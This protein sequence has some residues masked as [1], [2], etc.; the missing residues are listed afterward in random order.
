MSAIAGIL[1]LDGAP[2][3]RE[4]LETLITPPVW[5]AP[6]AHAVWLDGHVGMA[7]ALV[8]LTP[9]SED[10]RQPLVDPESGTVV[11][12][13][14]R[15]DNRAD[16]RAHLPRLSEADHD[17]AY[18]L[19]AHRRW[20]DDLP[21]HLIGDFD[22]AVWDPRKRTLLLARDPLGVKTLYYADVGGMLVFASTL[23]QL[24]EDERIPRTVDERSALG[25]LYLAP[26]D[27]RSFY[28][29]IESLAPGHSLVVRPDG[30]RTRIFW[31]PPEHPPERAFMNA[32]DLEEYREVFT[33]VVRSRLRTRDPV[34]IPLSG[35]LDSGSIGSVAGWLARE[36]GV[37]PLRSYTWAFDRLPIADERP[38][39]RAVTDKYDLPLTLVPAD[40]LLALTGIESFLPVLN[41]PFTNIYDTT[42]LRVHEVAREEGVRT[43]FSTFGADEMIGGTA[44]YF[45]DWLL[46]GHWLRLYRQLRVRGL[47]GARDFWGGA[48]IPLLP[49]A[50]QRA[51]LFP[52]VLE[53]DGWKPP[54][55]D[56]P[57]EL[58]GE[59][60]GPSA[61]WQLLVKAVTWEGRS[62]V[63]AHSDRMARLFGMQAS[64]PFL[65]V[66]LV[67]LCLRLPPDA[68]YSMARTKVIVRDGLHDILPPL[69][70]DRT[71]KPGVPPLVDQGLRGPALSF[72]RELMQ[73]SELE[74][75]GFVVAERWKRG[76]EKYLDGHD[77]LR[78]MIWVSLS[79]ELWLRKLEAR[80][81]PLPE[82]VPAVAH[83]ASLV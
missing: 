37:Q 33:E 17:P 77:N 40:H 53:L 13:D 29:E 24:F 58:P 26:L 19:A 14:G 55:M 22:L 75:R 23:E 57:R 3:D 30:R 5:P 31:K 56:I 43:I 20:G 7:C 35:G 15:L 49:P 8:R 12:F 47:N 34:G 63:H 18:V 4:R 9:E 78:G 21:S 42:L 51:R 79:L 81:P 61:W 2:V 25:Y 44:R 71:D 60:F 65:D 70:R 16:L 68:F 80:L 59:E 50:V 73:D 11:V 38:F 6:D 46:R 69:V 32:T 39:A 27:R 36:E 82:P 45:A 10:E 28:R 66:R 74:R 83:A 54:G 67:D 48:I 62:V 1:S 64:H 76:V 41:E 72:V 52:W